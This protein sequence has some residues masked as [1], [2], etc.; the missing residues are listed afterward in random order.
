MVTQKGKARDILSIGKRLS[1]EFEE[2]PVLKDKLEDLRRQ[3]DDSVKMSNDRLSLLEQAVPLANHFQ[4]T[5]EDI[6]KWM[7]E[8]EEQIREQDKPVGTPEQIKEHQDMVKVG[9]LFIVLQS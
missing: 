8:L 9:I 5:H 4:E 6:T 3:M 2:D 7:D 1:R